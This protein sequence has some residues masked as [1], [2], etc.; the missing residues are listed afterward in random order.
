VINYH[1][2]KYCKKNF[3]VFL[4]IHS[5]EYKKSFPLSLPGLNQTKVK[6]EG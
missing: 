2:A 3:I 4:I 5:G 1:F 6:E